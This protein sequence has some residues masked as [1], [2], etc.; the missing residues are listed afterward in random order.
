MNVTKLN[1][2][3]KNFIGILHVADIHIR[4]TKRH[5][6]YV[7]VFKKLYNVAHKTP[8]NTCI[9]VLGDV[10]HSKSDLSPECVKLASDF[11]KNLADIR[12]TV[13]IAGNHDATLNNKSRLDSI[14]PII[15]AL[16]HKNLFYL[17]DTGLFIL[18]DILFNHMSVFDSMENYIKSSDIPNIYRNETKHLVGLFHGSI[19]MAITDMGYYVS[20]SL[21]KPDLFDDHDLVLVGDIHKHQV[22]ETP[23]SKTKIV[24]PG[25]LIQQN[26]GEELNGHG[27]VM[28]NL[29][30]RTFKQLDIEN[31]YGFYTIDINKG[32]LTT[33][34]SNLPKKARLR[35]K[36]FE[37]VASEVKSVVSK[38]KENNNIDEI[39]Y[40]RVDTDQNLSK[41]LTNSTTLNLTDLSSVDYQNQLIKSYLNKQFP[42]EKISNEMFDK[43]FEINKHYNQHIDRDK[44]ARNIRWKPKTL[45]FSNMFSYGENN[46]IDFSKMKNTIGLFAPNASGKSSILSAL[47]FC[48][49]DKCDRA[50]KASHVLNS[51]KVSFSCKFNFEIDK[52]DYFIER[53][54]KSDKKGNVKVDVKFWKE[55]NEKII[56]LN[57]EARRSTNDM[58]RDYL[59]SYEDFIL[60]VLSIQNNKNGTFVDM[61]QTERKD[62]I[63]QFMGVNI[64]DMLYQKSSDSLKELSFE[65]KSISKDIDKNFIP[66][67]ENNL[68]NLKINVKGIQNKIEELNKRK[69]VEN[70][71]LLE[72]TKKI[73][74]LDISVSTNKSELELDSKTILDL[75]LR[76]KTEKQSNENNFLIIKKEKED[77]ELEIKKIEDSNIVSLYQ[78]LVKLKNK[79][80]EIKHEIEKKKIFVTSKLEKI[81]KLKS[82][83]YDPNCKYCIDNSFVRDAMDAQTSL[84]Q[85]KVDTDILI[86]EYN[87]V[88]LCIE[89]LAHVSDLYDKYNLLKQKNTKL[90]SEI[91]TLT[92]NLLKLDNTL[93]SI[94]SKF[95]KITADLKNYTD[96][97]SNIKHNQLVEKNIKD[98]N[99]YIKVIDNDL[100]RNTDELVSLSSKVATL[101]KELSYKKNSI[102]KIDEIQKKIDAYSLY[103]Q[104]VSR[105]GIPFE[106]ITNAAP[107]IEK[108]VNSILNQIVEFSVNIQTDGKNVMTYLVYNDKKWP[109]ELASGLEKF[110]TSLA[111]RVALI[112]ISNLPRPNFMAV[113]EGWG[114]MDG[115]NLSSVSALFS[116]L[117]NSFDF[118][119]VISH[120]DSMKDVVD[121]HLEI[122]KIDGFSSVKFI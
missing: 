62:L 13:V 58:I 48:I 15:D 56:E 91:S 61:G 80:S 82:H 41:N 121:N 26:H 79:S 68:E 9:A 40:I 17:K 46:I 37:S 53:T 42:N 102:D 14:S 99:G 88:N 69:E 30:Q 116:I 71:R 44:L 33:D 49:F 6:E 57:G 108:E 22:L 21:I 76:T 103:V 18:G 118:I 85:D 25:S 94:E 81:Q 100:R 11:L 65:L 2:D 75:I 105:D 120:I 119:L 66:T 1:C 45:E 115:N 28:W 97:E 93:Q 10:F 74:K 50:F 117:K 112:N 32:K 8:T 89:K 7:D 96:Q 29:N 72:E 12:P 90:D 84:V 87:E 55:E 101:E 63:S 24:Y 23:K 38:I 34:L 20:N 16:Q 107:I 111:I 77:V 5:E 70:V 110:L 64:F 47:S 3:V 122:N 78:D 83:R 4:L 31:D 114:T 98:I 36:C 39:T 60:T 51:Q 43:I 106:L 73:I 95:E 52:V 27:Y 104:S 113:D 67:L 35:V 54:G 19:H 59:G 86:K 92:N 109:L